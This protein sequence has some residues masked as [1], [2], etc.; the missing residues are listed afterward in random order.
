MA[1]R[2][3]QLRK[4]EG[5]SLAQVADRVGAQPGQ[6]SKL[7]RGLQR[8]TAD[9]A[10]KLAPVLGR[11]PADL[12]DEDTQLSVPLQFTVASAFAADRPDFELAEP[13]E[14]LVPP[15]RLK[16]PEE[17]VAAQIADDSV[18]KL[19]PRGAILVVRR[20]E[21]L[22]PPLRVGDKVL[23]R[24]FKGTRKEGET[25]EVL[26]GILDRSLAGDLSLLL[27][28]SQR[29]LPLAVTIRQ[30]ASEPARGMRYAEKER[31]FAPGENPL[32][33]GPIDYQPLDGDPAEIIGR[34]VL[35]ITPED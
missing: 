28:T 7:E 31:Y 35:A 14:R 32:D 18:D 16:A 22:D 27:R 10:R 29:E 33:K 13:I 2:L 15:R 6:I 3:R 4:R 12:I 24:R 21:F 17:C 30:A 9:W 19:Y 25:M 26:A 11:A 1:S 20:V 34:I 8:V 23:A 5:L